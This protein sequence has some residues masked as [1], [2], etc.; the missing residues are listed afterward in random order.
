M[1]LSLFAITGSV[2]KYY[3]GYEQ[4]QTCEDFRLKIHISFEYFPIHALN[5]AEIMVVCSSGKATGRRG[6]NPRR[7]ES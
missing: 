7:S 1:C 6:A 2:L 4:I 5:R 3:S